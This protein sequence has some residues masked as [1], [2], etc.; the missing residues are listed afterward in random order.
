MRRVRAGG[1]AKRRVLDRDA[2]LAVRQDV[3]DFGD[4][5]GNDDR[6]RDRGHP[7]GRRQNEPQGETPQLQATVRARTYALIENRNEGT[8]RGDQDHGDASG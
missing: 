4:R 6:D 7:G 8:K 3:P 1:E 5:C 2:P